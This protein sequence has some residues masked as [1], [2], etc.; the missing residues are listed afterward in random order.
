MYDPARP[1]GGPCLC[2]PVSENGSTGEKAGAEGRGGSSFGFPGVRTIQQLGKSTR[3]LVVRCVPGRKP[4]SYVGYKTETG[5]TRY[6]EEGTGSAP[7]D[8]RLGDVDEGA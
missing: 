8:A 1:S 2:H 5:Q 3:G 7:S 6:V 4:K